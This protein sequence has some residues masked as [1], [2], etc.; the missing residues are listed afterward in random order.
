MEPEGSLPHSQDPH[1]LSLSW[2]RSIQSM[3]PSHF[4][5]IHSRVQAVTSRSLNGKLHYRSYVLVL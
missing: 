1:H 4:W 3:P 2:A 5:N